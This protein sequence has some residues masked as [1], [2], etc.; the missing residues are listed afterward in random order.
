MAQMIHGGRLVARALKAEQVECLFTLCGGHIQAIY[1]GCLTEGIRVVD[2]RHEQSA[3][4]AA[5]GW[6][7]ATGQV[8][9][10]RRHGRSRRDRRRDRRRQRVP[11]AGVPMVMHRRR[12]PQRVQAHG[13]A[14]GHGPRGAHA[15]HHQV[16]RLHH[17]GAPYPRVHGHRLPQGDHRR[18][19]PGLPR[20]AARPPHGVPG[21]ER[22]PHPGQLAHRRPLAPDQEYLARAAELLRNAERPMAIMGS[23]LRWSR[24]PEGSLAGS[25]T[26]STSRSTSTAW[27]AAS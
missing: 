21:R 1:D 27:P 26:P 4:H 16:V 22:L 8:G 6:A 25:S 2:V 7:R 11:R 23:Q 24:D 17:R 13:L 19:R 12:G 15:A 3:G 10:V 9:R 5:D 20:D 14:S 18:P